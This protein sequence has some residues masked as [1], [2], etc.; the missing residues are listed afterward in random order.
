MTNKKRKKKKKKTNETKRGSLKRSIKLEKTSWQD[1][2]RAKQREDT[3]YQYQEWKRAI[4]TH[5]ADSKRI[6]KEYNKQFY[7]PKYGNLN[8]MDQFLKKHYLLQITQYEIDNL[9]SH[10]TIK[11]IESI[12]KLLP[13]MK[14]SGSDSNSTKKLKN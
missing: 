3:N 7:I 10:L 14:Y 2:Q 5:P 8:E 11:E 1:G 6:I 4:T 13:K 9:N 12:I